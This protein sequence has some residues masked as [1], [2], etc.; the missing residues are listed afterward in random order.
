MSYCTVCGGKCKQDGTCP[1]CQAKEGK[2]KQS[3]KRIILIAVIAAAVI[4]AIVGAVLLLNDDTGDRRDSSSK[5]HRE[6][7]TYDESG[8]CGASLRWGFNEET[9]EL[10]IFGEG[11][12][13]NYA[14]PD[15]G[16]NTAPWG[17]LPVRSVNMEGGRSIGYN[18]FAYC[19]DLEEVQIADTVET[20]E[21]LRLSIAH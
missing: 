6:E 12:M 19:F 7:S 4:A 21:V 8:T 17:R 15:E 3:K 10:T 14:V 20:L 9:G 2:K 16:H 13:D 11:Y 18:A 1:A 5:R